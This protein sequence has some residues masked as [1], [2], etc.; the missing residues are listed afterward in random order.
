M[1][2]GWFDAPAEAYNAL[3]GRYGPSLAVALAGF[4]E[5]PEGGR[6]LDVGCGTGALTAALA[7]RL[8]AEALAAVDPSEPFA[9]AC[10]ERVP[11]AD[12]RIAAADALPFGDGA[13]DVALAQLVFNFL[14]DAAAGVR[15]M[16]R[17]VRPG[18]I[19]GGCVWDYS[20]GMVLLRAFWDAA[21][22][23][24]PERAA[25]ADE[26][27]T[28]RLAHD[29]ELAELLRSAGLRDVRAGSLLAEARYASFEDLWV[30]FTRGA[31]PAGAYCAAL[32]RDAQA[33]LGAALRGRL[34]VGDA[35]FTLTARAWAAVGVVA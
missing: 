27:A 8:G 3:V 1:T 30:P 18:G 12:V 7:E 4:A 24:D 19:V 16:A 29:G 17:V 31:G 32:G 6:A 10:R 28:M 14:P 34:G 9:A 20:G 13:F 5:V 35:P 2:S 21:L 25:A 15:E 11:G 23:L 33:A 22:E 26:G